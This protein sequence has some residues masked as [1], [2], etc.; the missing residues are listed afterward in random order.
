M[1]D[2]LETED[3][4]PELAAL[5]GN[6]P[7]LASKDPSDVLRGLTARQFANIKQQSAARDKVS[8]SKRAAFEAGL[9]EIKQRRYGAP[10]PSQQLYALSAALLSPRRQP[11]IAGTLANVVPALG[12][13]SK[14]QSSA[15]TQ[16]AEAEQRLRQQYASDTDASML[17]GLEAEGAALEPLIRAYGSLAKPRAPRTAL[18]E[19]NILFD[20]DTGEEIVPVSQKL[21]QV[22]PNAIETL[23][24]KLADPNLSDGDKARERVAFETYYNVPV[25]RALRGK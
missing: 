23:R 1:E 10:T 24:A 19:N 16:R 6:Y 22:P 21:A 7:E 14:L 25:N 12:E 4:N 13:M 11:G 15:E 5:S 20:L 8:A 3:M 18:G 9:E 2:D 17:A